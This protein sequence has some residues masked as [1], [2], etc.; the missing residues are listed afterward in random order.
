LYGVSHD[1]TV[2]DRH[3]HGVVNVLL[4]SPWKHYLRT[5]YVL[6]Y[7]G[8][9]FI[10]QNMDLEYSRSQFRDIFYNFSGLKMCDLFLTVI[11]QAV[12]LIVKKESLTVTDIRC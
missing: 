7:K 2:Q 10:N 9:T 4:V 8:Y 6:W 5:Y 3:S 11:F 12:V 1:R